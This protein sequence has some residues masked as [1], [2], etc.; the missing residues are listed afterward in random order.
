MSDLVENPED[1]F[2]R[3]AAHMIHKWSEVT[4]SLIEIGGTMLI[5]QYPTTRQRA[6]PCRLLLNGSGFQSLHS[7]LSLVVLCC[8]NLRCKK[9]GCTT[10]IQGSLGV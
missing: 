3:V 4:E 2:S 9:F 10:G 8:I 6:L 7:I 5:W 1:R